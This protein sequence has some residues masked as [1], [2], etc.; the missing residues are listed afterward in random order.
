VA[1]LEAEFGPARWRGAHGSLSDLHAARSGGASRLA[2][3]GAALPVAESPLPS[4]DCGE[5]GAGCEARS[6]AVGAGECGAGAPSGEPGGGSGPGLAR[7]LTRLRGGH[8]EAPTARSAVGGGRGEGPSP[9]VADALRWAG[10]RPAGPTT[11]AGSQ[12]PPVSRGPR[13]PRAGPAVPVA[14][15]E[16]TP[17]AHADRAPAAHADRAPAAHAV[18][19]PGPHGGAARSGAAEA[20]T[21]TPFTAA[22]QLPFSP[23]ETPLTQGAG[24]AAWPR[25]AP[26]DAGHLVTPGAR[27]PPGAPAPPGA[28]PARP[29]GDSPETQ[30]AQVEQ[31]PSSGSPAGGA[32]TGASTPSSGGPSSGSGGR[33]GAGAPSQ[34]GGRTPLDGALSLA[35]D[36]RAAAAASFETF[37]AAI[38]AAIAAV[39]AERR[40]PRPASAPAGGRAGFARAA[41]L[42]GAEAGGG[43][44]A[45]PLSLPSMP[46]L[47][48]R[49]G[50]PRT[51]G[52]SDSGSSHAS[53]PAQPSSG[54]GSGASA[55]PDAAGRAPSAAVKP[56]HSAPLHGAVSALALPLPPL[57][58]RPRPGPPRG[59]KGSSPEPGRRAWL[60]DTPLAGSGG[61]GGPSGGPH[62]GSHEGPYRGPYGVPASAPQQWL[63]PVTAPGVFAWKASPFA[64][65]AHD[66][67]FE[68]ERAAGSRA[69]AVARS[70]F[71]C[72]QCARLL[73]LLF[74]RE[75]FFWGCILFVYLYY[76]YY[77]LGWAVLG[78]ALALLPVVERARLRHDVAAPGS[79]LALSGRGAAAEAQRPQQPAA[80]TA[81]C[82]CAGPRRP[83]RPRPACSARP[84][85]PCTRCAAR[86]RWASR[87]CRPRAAAAPARRRP[88]HA[89]CR[90]RAR[91][92][93]R[94]PA[95]PRPPLRATAGALLPRLLRRPEPRCRAQGRRRR[96]RVRRRWCAC[97][98]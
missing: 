81:W 75:G 18:S 28:A 39:S 61:A 56:C 52:L 68:H 65:A 97:S 83:R 49:V 16:C 10:Q 73:M 33:G 8:A 90:G 19:V 32:S 85:P 96:C 78:G 1:R 76:Y 23:P 5:P 82:D 64:A 48:I 53:A 50:S 2:S 46:K 77:F 20:A 21:A 37:E 22:S 66:G 35:D 98:G 79:T 11:C 17:A 29:P 57:P 69:E 12:A 94:R 24:P 86:A 93:P 9:A 13:Q 67:A 58:V 30:E 43:D 74:V 95:P 84:T 45:A 36:P 34:R 71:W 25:A 27:A 44:W 92:C 14:H 63:A 26:R 87:R 59:G 42:G 55:G 60:P 72:G 47:R 80:E 7:T 41:G 6:G 62:Q 89:R 88:S 70:G 31:S 15:A 4:A 40:S 54:A 3:A 38:N 51:A 91:S